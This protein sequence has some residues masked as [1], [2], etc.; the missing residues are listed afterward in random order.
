M[1]YIQSDSLTR[2]YNQYLGRFQWRLD[3]QN[4]VFST[5]FGLPIYYKI[6]FHRTVATYN[7]HILKT[8]YDHGKKCLPTLIITQQNYIIDSMLRNVLNFS[9]R[10]SDHAHHHFL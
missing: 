5:E 10:L 7:Y 9:P 1:S 3:F 8:N 4:L 2:P 6:L